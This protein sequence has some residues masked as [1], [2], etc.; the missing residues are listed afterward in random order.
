[1]I[2]LHEDEDYISFG[3]QVQAEIDNREM[4]RFCD[5]MDV[6]NRIRQQVAQ[7]ILERPS[8]FVKWYSNGFEWTTQ[9]KKRIMELLE[10]QNNS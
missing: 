9:A 6:P 1:M 8:D 10:D 3:E 4:A 5:N 7:E 2:E